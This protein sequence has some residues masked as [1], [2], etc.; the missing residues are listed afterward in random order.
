MEGV[1]YKEVDSACSRLCNAKNKL[2]YGNSLKTML[3]SIGESIDRINRIWNTTGGHEKIA[4]FEELY[5]GVEINALL[6]ILSEIKSSTATF[7]TESFQHI[8]NN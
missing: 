7:S 4:K 5:T 8:V 3:D 6:N 1:S 2:T